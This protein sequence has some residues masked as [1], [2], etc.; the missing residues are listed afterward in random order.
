MYQE[1]KKEYYFDINDKVIN[2]TKEDIIYGCK[3][4]VKNKAKSWDLITEKCIKST[5]KKIEDLNPVYEN[6]KIILNRYL[7]L[8]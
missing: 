3:N 8:D 5:L 6:I 7:I 1:I 2:I 4:L